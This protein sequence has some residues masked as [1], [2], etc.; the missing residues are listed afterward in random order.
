MKTCSKFTWVGGGEEDPL[1]SA[2]Y[3][4]TGF[5]WRQDEAKWVTSVGIVFGLHPSFRGSYLLFTCY[6]L[7][8]TQLRIS[9]GSLALNYELVSFN[10]P[11]LVPYT[12]VPMILSNYFH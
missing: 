1:G 6:L 2:S 7:G 11:S 9:K 8:A 5:L 3:F 12:A 10:Q 4:A